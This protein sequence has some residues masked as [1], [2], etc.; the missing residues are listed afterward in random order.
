VNFDQLLL[1]KDFLLVDFYADWCEPCKWVEPVLDEVIKS[2]NGKLV[3]HKINIDEHP[4]IAR[5]YHVLSVPTIVLFK[6]GNELWRMKGFDVAPK[7]FAI[8]KPFV[9]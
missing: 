3:L 5:R 2:F 9:L 1:S 4:D 8:I 7:L 6:N